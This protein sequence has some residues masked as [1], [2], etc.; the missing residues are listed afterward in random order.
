[1][2]PQFFPKPDELRIW[3]IENH[4]SETELFVGYYKKATGIP[5]IDWPESVDEALCFGWIDGRRNSIDDKSYQIRFTPRNPKSHWSAVNIDKIQKLIKE[6]KMYPAGMEAWEKRDK[7][8]QMKASYEQEVVALSPEFL[9]ALK[10]NKKAFEYFESGIAPFYKK[11]SIHWVMSAK[12]EETRERRL[13]KL[14]ECCENRELLPAFRWS[15][16]EK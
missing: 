8:K 6:D 12:K 4:Q 7:S 14:I 1:M 5:S 13:A 9:K 15:K 16:K 3:F 10:K 2:K 11:L